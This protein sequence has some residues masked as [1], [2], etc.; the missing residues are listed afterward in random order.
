MRDW[1][2]RWRSINGGSLSGTVDHPWA[3][4]AWGGKEVEWIVTGKGLGSVGTL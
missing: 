2:S 1:K 3:G 4:L